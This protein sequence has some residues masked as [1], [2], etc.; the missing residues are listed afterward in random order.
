MSTFGVGASQSWS[1]QRSCRREPPR[2]LDSYDVV[3]TRVLL[4]LSAPNICGVAHHS[5]IVDHLI[6]SDRLLE[7]KHIF[8]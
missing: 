6:S 5:H 2:S 1:L 3:S 8:N 7:L 4:L